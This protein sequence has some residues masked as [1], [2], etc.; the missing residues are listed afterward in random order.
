M[1]PK[2]ESLAI[3]PASSFKDIRRSNVSD[4][5]LLSDTVEGLISM[6][7]V[8]TLQAMFANV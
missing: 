8:P 3:Y 5:L 7:D 4:D 1:D 6:F 2:K